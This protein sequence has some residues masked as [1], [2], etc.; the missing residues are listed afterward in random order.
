MENLMNDSI[1]PYE[2]RKIYKAKGKVSFFGVLLVVFALNQV[3]CYEYFQT[4]YMA[5]FK[6]EGQADMWFRISRLIF[7]IFVMIFSLPLAKKIGARKFFLFPV[8][9]LA[10]VNVVNLYLPKKDHWLLFNLIYG[11]VSGIAAGCSS[12]V[13]YYLIWGHVAPENKILVTSIFYFLTYIFAMRIL[14]SLLNLIWLKS[15]KLGLAQTH[16]IGEIHNVDLR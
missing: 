1:D 15:M 11:V 12:I 5:I 3:E 8:I 4:Y 10:V 2:E 14:P 13:P 9:L 16:R 6:N 7:M